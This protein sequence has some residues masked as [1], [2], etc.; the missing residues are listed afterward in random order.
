[1]QRRLNRSVLR[2][3]EFQGRWR[4]DEVGFQYIDGVVYVRYVF[5]DL[6]TNQIATRPFYTTLDLRKLAWDFND[7]IVDIRMLEHHLK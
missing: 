6:K 1:M 5:K 2:D 7:F 3:K 4:I